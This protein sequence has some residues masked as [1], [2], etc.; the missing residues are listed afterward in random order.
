LQIAQRK[1]TLAVRADRDA[2][3]ALIRFSIVLWQRRFGGG[4]NVLGKTVRLDRE[5]ATIIGV[6]PEGWMLLNYPAQFWAP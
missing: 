5:V 1:S 6:M 2:P 3:R 4:G